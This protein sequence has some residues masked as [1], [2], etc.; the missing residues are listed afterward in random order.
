ME[1]S[2]TFQQIK[3]YAIK[4]NLPLIPF[5]AKSV[6]ILNE[7]SAFYDT[8]LAKTLDAKKRVALSALYIGGGVE[9]KALIQALRDNLEENRKL[10]VNIAL[11]AHRGRR[12]DSRGNSSL[13]VIGDGLGFDVVALN[14][15]QTYSPSGLLQR[16]LSKFQKWNEL[17]STYHSKLMLFDEDVIITGANLSGIYFDQRQDRYMTIQNTKSFSD[18]IQGFLVELDRSTRPLDVTVNKYNL[19]Y[20]NSIDS[21]KTDE[22]DDS[23]I[24]PL[25]QHGISG[26]QDCDDFLMFL[27][28]ILPESAQL[29]LSS[30]YFNPRIKL[31][32]TSA[33]VPSEQ[34][35]GFFNGSKL[36]KYVPR[37]YT[38]LLDSYVKSNPECRVNLYNRPDW[39]YHAKGLWIEGLED[40]TI[41]MIG[42]SNFNW[43]STT[44]DFE[45]QFL[46]ITKDRELGEKLQKERESLWANSRPI[47]RDD[48]EGLNF[49]YRVAAN[50]LK[51]LL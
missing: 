4:R 49:L 1:L 36:L 6:S 28:G 25:F 22:N 41:H 51:S 5:C 45:M 46:I 31:K 11:D 42:S 3:A 18:Y 12:F 32:L 44:R 39:S 40:L 34:A 2:R 17:H 13:S 29:H 26:I 7:P 50:I 24:V 10:D 9:E 16:F 20:K 35:N 47:Q 21:T 33:L 48:F 15:V 27:Q 38:A 43:R 30:G 8:L 37:L 23:F 14:L 19:D